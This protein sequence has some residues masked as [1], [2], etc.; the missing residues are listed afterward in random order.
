MKR[1]VVYGQNS[2]KALAAAVIRSAMQAHLKG[3]QASMTEQ[4]KRREP[5]R[6][7]N[8]LQGDMFPWSEMIDLDPETDLAFRTWC[9]KNGL[10]AGKLI[11]E[12]V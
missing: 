2:Y 9:R 8:F 12:K 3:P 10:Q 1:S 6:V 7:A 5:G 4:E 11:G